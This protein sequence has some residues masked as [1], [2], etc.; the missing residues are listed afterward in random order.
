M[1][2]LPLNQ[3]SVDDIAYAEY[4]F[5]RFYPVGSTGT[6]GV[7]RLGYTETEDEMHDIFRQLGEEEGY[8]YITDE[9]GNSYLA[10][11]DARNYYLIASHL[12]SVIEGGRY[13]GVAGVLAGM[14]VLHWIKENGLDIPVRVGA[15]RCEESSNFG[16]CTI[17]SGLITN[18]VYKYD[19]G[20]SV[21]KNGETLSEIFKKKGY[22]LQPRR[23][24]GIRKY[25]E[26]HIEQGKVL[27][28]YCDKLGIVSTIAGPRR[29]ILHIIGHAEHSGA[30]PMDMRN[31]ALCGAA[32]IITEIESIGR[33]EAIWKSVATVG[34]IANEPNA[35]NVIPGEVTLGV[36]MRGVNLDSLNRMENRLKTSAK[37]ICEKRGLTFYKE[38]ISEIPPIDM[39]SE[40]QEDLSRVA[41]ELKIPHRIM[42][43]GAG[44][45]AMSFA[46]LCDTAL[47][48]I[49]CDKGVSHSK[50]EFATIESICDGAVVMYEYLKR[51]AQK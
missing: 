12:D 34:T 2:K 25:L 16:K 42:M 6:G 30:T 13:D 4:V 41:K 48:F 43:S 10:N 17:G 3:Y 33:E 14:V 7:T 27:E 5:D 47:L 24:E 18:E 19:V 51:E 50:H 31:D 40:M 8:T 37:R 39:S 20:S 44:H 45:D 35:L 49:P 21:A 23:I 28:E 32:E 36:D 38:K 22:S 29:F 26:L 9:V 46:N 15:F 1:A 11:S